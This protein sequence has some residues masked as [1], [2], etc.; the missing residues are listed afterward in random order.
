MFFLQNLERKEKNQ[1]VFIDQLSKKQRFLKW[2]VE[3]LITYNEAMCK[4]RTVSECSTSS[5][6]SSAS[7]LTHS[8][9][10]CTRSFTSIS[11][12]GKST[13]LFFYFFFNGTARST[14]IYPNISQFKSI[15]GARAQLP[16]L[17]VGCVHVTHV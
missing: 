13:N 8:P 1:T 14:N 11:E 10:E 15:S 16:L 3:Q 6:L 12:S 9:V 5:T 17:T 7:I 4:R 2:R